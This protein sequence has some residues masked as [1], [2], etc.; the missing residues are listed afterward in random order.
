MTRGVS[1]RSHRAPAHAAPTTATATIIRRRVNRTRGSLI[2]GLRGS[3]RV[4]R[5]GPTGPWRRRGA[6]PGAADEFGVPLVL[7]LQDRDVDPTVVAGGGGGVVV[8]P[9]ARAYGDPHGAKDVLAPRVLAGQR[10]L[11]RGR[12]GRVQDRFGP[13]RQAGVVGPGVEA[14]RPRDGARGERDR[15]PAR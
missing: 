5:L 8:H 9:D 10:D 1:G 11:H 4:S 12:V 15:H 7:A 6:E 2:P 3:S 13:L 14:A